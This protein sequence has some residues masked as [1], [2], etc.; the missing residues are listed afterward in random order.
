MSLQVIEVQLSGL[1]LD[2]LV[3]GVAVAMGTS[4]ERAAREYKQAAWARL[5]AGA[6]GIGQRAALLRLALD[7]GS[8][9]D[10]LPLVNDIRLETARLAASLRRR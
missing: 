3:P 5:L 1:E 10:A 2:G 8:R 6:D 7:R 9:L 4:P